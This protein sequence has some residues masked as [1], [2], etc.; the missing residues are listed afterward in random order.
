MP[1]ITVCEQHQFSRRLQIDHV[2][3]I[4]D[5]DAAMRDKD[6]LIRRMEPGSSHT[7][8]PVMIGNDMKVAQVDHIMPDLMS[9]KIDA[10]F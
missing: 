5:D 2:R 7:T 1:G 4:G 9:D 8:R 3:P 10:V 6:P